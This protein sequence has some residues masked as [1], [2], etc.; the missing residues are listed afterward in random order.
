MPEAK[1]HAGV[2]GV[3]KEPSGRREI[4]GAIGQVGV[5]HIFRPQKRFFSRLRN[6]P[7][8]QARNVRS[9]SGGQRPSPSREFHLMTHL[10]PEGPEPVSDRPVLL[11]AS[12]ELRTR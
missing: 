2:G 11:F 10:L 6:E 9:G 8:M 7:Q 12:I 3:P 4:I 5:D 1:L